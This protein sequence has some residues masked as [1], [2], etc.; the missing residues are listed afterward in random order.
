MELRVFTE[1]LFARAA[2]KGLLECEVYCVAGSSFSS[3]VFKGEIV[4]YSVSDAVGL[5]FRALVN[6]KMGYA[7][8]QAFDDDAI[9]MLIS[10]ARTNAELIGSEDA[11]FLFAGGGEYAKLDLYSAPLEAVTAAEKIALARGKK[12]YDKRQTLRERQDNLEAHRAMR[13]RELT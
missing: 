13:R 4:D 10:A 9:E 3:S 7:S 11:Q 8:T 12:E 1:K 2:E 6:G 5:G